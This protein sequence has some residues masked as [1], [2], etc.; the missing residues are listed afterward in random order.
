MTFED[1]SWVL[2][3][4]QI[5]Q[6][7]ATDGAAN[8]GIPSIGARPGTTWVRPETLIPI[9]GDD[10]AVE[11]AILRETLDRASALLTILDDGGMIPA[12][13]VGRVLGA[14]RFATGQTG[15][16]VGAAIR[17]DLDQWRARNKVHVVEIKNMRARILQAG[18]TIQ[19]MVARWRRFRSFF[20]AVES[21]LMAIDINGYVTVDADEVAAVRE[22]QHAAARDIFRP[23]PPQGAPP[24]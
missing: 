4:A 24:R 5:N 12:V 22:A 19:E 11:N 23:T 7:R 15:R 8:I 1:Q 20:A 21:L 17:E 18:T 9:Y 13:D 3:R 14:I 6:T 2:V 16:N 10:V